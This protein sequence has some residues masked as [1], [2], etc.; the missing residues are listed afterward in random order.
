MNNLN[1]VIYYYK[2]TEMIEDTNKM[3][4]VVAKMAK[5]AKTTKMSNGLNGRKA[6]IRLKHTHLF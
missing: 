1:K 2:M 3:G 5:M 4:K 6:N